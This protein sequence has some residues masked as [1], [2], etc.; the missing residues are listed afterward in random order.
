[1]VAYHGVGGRVLGEGGVDLQPALTGGRGRTTN[2]SASRMCP[3]L[4]LPCPRLGQLFCAFAGAWARSRLFPWLG[5][6]SMDDSGTR[7]AHWKHPY[8]GI[9][10]RMHA[11]GGL[12]AWSALTA[13]PLSS[14]STHLLFV[15]SL[16][17]VGLRPLPMCLQVLAP[18][19]VKRLPEA[20]VSPVGGLAAGS[21]TSG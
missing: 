14:L 12:P 1:M 13:R 7:A 4:H 9:S 3:W 21:T 19:H 16:Q 17:V 2:A 18:P 10:C 11:C 8:L 6:P 20:R 15:P 5:L